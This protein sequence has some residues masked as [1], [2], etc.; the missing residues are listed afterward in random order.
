MPESRRG[1]LVRRLA[2]VADDLGPVV[3]GDA[4]R[5]LWAVVDAARAAFDA[6]AC[7]LAEVNA[8]GTELQWVAASGVGA[9]Q[10][11]GM[12]LLLTQGIAGFVASSGQSLIID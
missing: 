6:A 5:L 4:E 12:R 3:V 10:T 2:A 9:E 8:E 11:V 1:D 7:S